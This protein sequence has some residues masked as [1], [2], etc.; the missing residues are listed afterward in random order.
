[1]GPDGVRRHAG[2][3]LEHFHVAL[4]V[5]ARRHRNPARFQGLDRPQLQETVN[6]HELVNRQGR[7]L[8]RSD[9]YRQGGFGRP[10]DSPGAARRLL[11]LR[12][13]SLAAYALSEGVWVTFRF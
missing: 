3:G 7:W 11:K 4:V 9:N 5:G 2:G 10:S 12:V 8:R 6:R 1:M 13:C